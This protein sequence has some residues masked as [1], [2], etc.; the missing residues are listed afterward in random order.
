MSHTNIQETT[1]K[2]QR[3]SSDAE[4][5]TQPEIP[6][7]DSELRRKD[8]KL[9]KSQR[10]WEYLISCGCERWSLTV[11]I[12]KSNSDDDDFHKYAQ[13][14]KFFLR[15]IREKLKQIEIH[16]E[17]APQTVRKREREKIWC[18]ESNNCLNNINSIKCKWRRMKKPRRACGDFMPEW[19]LNWFFILVLHS[20][21]CGGQRRKTSFSPKIF[22]SNTA[23]M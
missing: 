5:R 12:R 10:I 14:E 3:S 13:L 6:F 7:E 22:Q 15:A 8:A 4:L 23:G 17:S 19:H 21:E 18:A 1:A 11:W 9:R 2:Y 20:H 16:V